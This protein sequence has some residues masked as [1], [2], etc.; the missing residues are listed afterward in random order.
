MNLVILID[1]IVMY[2]TL[3]RANLFLS[4][5]FVYYLRIK[6]SIFLFLLFFIR[7]I[8]IM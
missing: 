5:Y 6:N 8:N 7:A 3:S 1:S 4:Q 2:S